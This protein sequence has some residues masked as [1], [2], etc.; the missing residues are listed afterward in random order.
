MQN[1]FL[2]NRILT[3]FVLRK[4]GRNRRL[5]VN[6]LN[7]RPV[8]GEEFNPSLPHLPRDICRVEREVAAGAKM[9][10]PV[11]DQFYGDRSGTLADPFGHLWMVATRK[12]DVSAEE[13]QKRFAALY[14]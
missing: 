13:M 10:R 1:D 7:S 6:N 11:Q 14:A 5:K 8:N 4:D 3:P 12:E 2:G 9:L